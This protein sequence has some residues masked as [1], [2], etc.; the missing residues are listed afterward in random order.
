MCVRPVA[1]EGV[2]N[3]ANAVDVGNGTVSRINTAMEA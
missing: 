1:G 3:I 2:K